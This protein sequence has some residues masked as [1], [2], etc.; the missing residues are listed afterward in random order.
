MAKLYRVTLTDEE[1]FTLESIIK[2]CQE[3]A[4]RTKRSYVLL[5]ADENG[6]KKWGDQEI[7]LCYGLSISA[8]ERLRKRFVEHG[9]QMA[10]YGK[11]REIEY[12]RI[13][14]GRVESQL[15]A[16]RCSDVPS[17]HSGWTLRLLA[18]KMVSLNYVESISHETV[19]QILKKTK[20][21]PG[22]LKGG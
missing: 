16:M 13:F 5:A 14:D 15:L 18:D 17:G 7:N 11:K 6:E 9:L 12:N 22:R 4:Q 20:L 1:R 3:G 21:N 8:I 19:R 2:K 10:L